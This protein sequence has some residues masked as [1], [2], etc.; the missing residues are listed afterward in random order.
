[1]E[2]ALREKEKELVKIKNMS[3]NVSPLQ[4][5]SCD[6]PTYTQETS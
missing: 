2:Q 6:C 1:M 3:D 5:A 4:L